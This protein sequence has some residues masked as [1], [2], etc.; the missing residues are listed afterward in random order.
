MN[1][2]VI[3]IILVFL[4]FISKYFVSSILIINQNI[5]INNFFDIVYIKNF[6]VSFGLFANTVPYWILVIIAILVVILILYLMI[7]SNKKLEKTAYFVIIIGAISNIADRAINGYVIDFISLHYNNFYW[8][9][10]NFADIYIT[11]GIIML[12]TS[13]FTKLEN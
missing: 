5:K 7:I 9:A 6:G 4:D 13:F 8:P 1:K 2:F 12:L 3:L 11:L 10:F